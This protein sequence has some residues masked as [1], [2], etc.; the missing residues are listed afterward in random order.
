MAY[1]GI[2]GGGSSSSDIIYSETETL[3]GTYLGEDLYRKVFVLNIT[4]VSSGSN[5]TLINDVTT[6]HIKKV[7][8]SFARLDSSASTSKYGTLMDSVWVNGSDAL[9]MRPTLGF[10]NITKFEL[11]LEYTKTSSN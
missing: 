4:Q 3:I 1:F 5:V 10:T 11:V 2:S 7:I 8:S 9:I 6:Y